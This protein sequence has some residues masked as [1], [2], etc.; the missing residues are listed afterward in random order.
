MVAGLVKERGIA[1]GKRQPPAA[2]IARIAGAGCALLFERMKMA[3]IP[4]RGLMTLLAAASVASLSGCDS[5]PW[6]IRYRGSGPWTIRYRLTLE[7][8]TPEG[9]KTGSGMIQHSAR[10]NDGITR[11]LGAGPGLALA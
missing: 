3:R 6:T 8:E 7:V 11:G 5:G 9:T 4:R 10:W 1:G 2:R